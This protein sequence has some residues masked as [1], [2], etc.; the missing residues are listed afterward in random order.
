[1]ALL[2]DAKA[3]AAYLFDCHVNRTS[4]EAMQGEIAP[5]TIDEVYQTQDE[6]AKLLV[7]TEGP[8]AGFKIATT[9]RVMQTLLG[10]DHP[11]GGL[12]FA[13]RIF[14]S[15]ARLQTAGY[16][17]LG[18]ECEVAVRLA[19]D[20]SAAEAPFT[21]AS[22]APAVAAVMPAFELI[23]DRNAGYK[24]PAQTNAL[25]LIAENGWN[26]G[27]VLGA[28]FQLGHGRSLMGIHGALKQNGA[29]IHTGRTEDPFDA[30]AWVATSAVERSYTLPAGSVVI[31]G[32]VIPTLMSVQPGD[33]L[34]FELAGLGSTSL[35]AV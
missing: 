29:V 12:I 26:A 34:E 2:F 28:P 27:V 22:V 8:I 15:P 7:K 4:Y 9:T 6:L 35:A 24:D 18:I 25:S 5:R 1:V 16:L 23:E 19:R 33:H 13:E 20:L 10:I 32:S 14:Q 30:L 31:T 17:N 21:A 3:T 11:C